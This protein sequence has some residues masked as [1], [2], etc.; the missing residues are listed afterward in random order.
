M[1]DESTIIS[2]FYKKDE[3]PVDDCA[4]LESTS[5]LISADAMIEDT[6]FR[7][8]WQ[9]PDQLAKKVFQSNLSDIAAGGGEPAWCMLQL[10]LPK[11]PDVEFLH[12]FAKAFRNEY[13]EADCPLI[14]GDTFRS[15]KYLF[16]IT[17]AGK[18]SRPVRRRANIGDLIYVTGS[19]GLSLAGLRHLQGNLH[20]SGKV[21]DLA[22]QKHLCPT[23]RLEWARQIRDQPSLHG[24]MDVSD[25]LVQDLARFAKASGHQFHLYLDSI[26]KH[27]SLTGILTQLDFAVS[28]EE[29]E[30][31]FCA[32]EAL[33]F[34]FEATPIGKVTE[35]DPSLVVFADQSEKEVIDMKDTGY[36]HFQ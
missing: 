26:P 20:L 13:E 2:L 11:H 27:E 17:I 14:G 21:K 28:A 23:A 12:E 31:V 6:H 18:T 24:M 34:D 15:E 29:Y 33:L 35:G 8:D 7:M 30:L 22:L 3:L 36:H 10:G 9:R 16:A 5:Q 1:I 25:G 19:L 4:F 32:D